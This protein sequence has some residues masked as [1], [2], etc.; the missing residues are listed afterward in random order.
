M[1]KQVTGTLISTRDRKPGR[2]RQALTATLRSLGHSGIHTLSREEVSPSGCGGRSRWGRDEVLK[3]DLRVSTARL[4][5]PWRVEVEKMGVHT[6][7]KGGLTLS[8]SAVCDPEWSNWALGIDR[9]KELVLNANILQCWVLFQLFT[10][11]LVEPDRRNQAISVFPL[12]NR[13]QQDERKAVL[14][15]FFSGLTGTEF[16]KLFP[17]S[18]AGRDSA[19][20]VCSKVKGKQPHW[21]AQERSLTPLSRLH[22]PI[23]G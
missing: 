4:A 18:C 7:T 2:W 6:H 3:N 19:D 13:M 5:V 15:P 12:C 1:G 8:T 23:T 21:V 10:N 14:L 11:E 22:Y 9:G 20:S 17:G 16:T